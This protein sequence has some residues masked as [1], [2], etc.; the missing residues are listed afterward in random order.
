MFLDSGR[1]GI[2]G[3][4]LG[5]GQASLDCAMEYASKRTSFGQ[6][7]MKLQL[8]Q[9]KLADMALKLESARLLTWRAAYLKDN[10]QS[11]TK[12]RKLK[13]KSMFPCLVTMAVTA[14]VPFIADI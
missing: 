6:P 5:I 13:Q 1:I 9:Q 2:A 8:I 12:V 3:Q 7:I 11:Y 10:K 4:A 14:N